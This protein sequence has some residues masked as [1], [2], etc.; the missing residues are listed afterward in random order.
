MP[1]SGLLGPKSGACFLNSETLGFLAWVTPQQYETGVEQT[2]R[3]R[4][5]SQISH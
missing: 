2:R 5:A 1:G 3:E 4:G